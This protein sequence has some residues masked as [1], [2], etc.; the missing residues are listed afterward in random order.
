M[1]RWLAVELSFK[2]TLVW[3]WSLSDYVRV[4]KKAEVIFWLFWVWK[5]QPLR[6]VGDTFN[7]L[8]KRSE[9]RHI[10]LSIHKD[11]P[12]LEQ[13]LDRAIDICPEKC[14]T[15]DSMRDRQGSSSSNVLLQRKKKIKWNQSQE[16]RKNHSEFE[17]RILTKSCRDARRLRFWKDARPAKDYAALWKF[18]SGRQSLHSMDKD[19]A[20][21]VISLDGFFSAKQEGIKL[22][23]KISKLSTKKK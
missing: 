23:Q 8:E 21:S 7:R 13:A 18:A 3:K 1:H 9:T 4:D 16:I 10:R 14:T 22:Q 6:F 20:S 12:V 2:N 5:K 11:K 17:V 19:D 15:T